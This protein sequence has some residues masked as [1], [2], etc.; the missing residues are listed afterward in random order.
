MASESPAEVASNTPY[1][2]PGRF[3]YREPLVHADRQLDPRSGARQVT[4]SSASERKC[5]HELRRQQRGK[6]LGPISPRPARGEGGPMPI[7]TSMSLAL[8]R[9][10]LLVVVDEPI[11]KDT[12]MHPLVRWQ[13]RGGIPEHAAQGV[14]VHPR[15]TEAAGRY[16]GAVLVAGL[17]GNR[18]IYR[19]G[20]GCEPRRHRRCVAA[21]DPRADYAAPGRE[22]AVP[23]HRHN[24]R[25]NSTGRAAGSTRC[26]CRS[27]RP[28]GTTDRICQPVTYI[29]KRSGHRR[30]ERRHLSRADQ[31]HAGVSG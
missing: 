16:K 18:G 1:A 13:Y 6:G 22:R 9:A 14:P 31:R 15:P 17:A 23:R 21:G 24:R 12:E 7:C 27:R 10:G 8:A 19:I 28:A 26:R 4:A 3:S 25:A 29:T 5:R 30:P 11:N 20:F 2:P